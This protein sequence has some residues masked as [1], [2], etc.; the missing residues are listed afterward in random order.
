MRIKWKEKQ[1]RTI[2]K[3]I[4]CTYLYEFIWNL[5]NRF[6]PFLLPS[7]LLPVLNSSHGFDENVIGNDNIKYTI[8]FRIRMKSLPKYAMCAHN[9]I[10]M[11][12]YHIHFDLKTLDRKSN[13]RLLDKIDTRNKIFRSIM[14]YDFYSRKR[15]IKKKMFIINTYTYY[16]F[17]FI[18]IQTFS[19]SGCKI[20]DTSLSHHVQSGVCVTLSFDVKLDFAW[21]P[22][23][24]EL[25]ECLNHWSH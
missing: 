23:G 20:I 21:T 14:L 9:S 6:P 4:Y 19:T 11:S 22:F 8:F 25:N 12:W 1:R 18:L 2:G 13:I 24:H 17:I 10:G 16:L 3:R 7:H 5:K 15:N